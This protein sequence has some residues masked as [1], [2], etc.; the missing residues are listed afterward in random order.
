MV[1]IWLHVLKTPKIVKKLCDWS[2]KLLYSCVPLFSYRV[3][4]VVTQARAHNLLIDL[5][6]LF[7]AIK[8]RCSAGWD[9]CMCVDLKFSMAGVKTAPWGAAFPVSGWRHASFHCFALPRFSLECCVVEAFV[10]FRSHLNN[11]VCKMKIITD[12]CSEPSSHRRERRHL[13][14][15]FSQK[16]LCCN[17]RDVSKQMPFLSWQA[18]LQSPQTPCV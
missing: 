9:L 7:S 17:L 10:S 8:L 18:Y 3:N 16:L 11:A 4:W 15:R 2:G 14:H 1:V 6:I 13:D 12:Y 5:C